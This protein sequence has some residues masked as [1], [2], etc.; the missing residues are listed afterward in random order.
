MRAVER[1]EDVRD[2]RL[3]ADRQARDS[4]SGQFVGHR[5]RDGVGVRFDGDLRSGGEAEGVTH[6]LQ[7]AC[8]V[9][10]GKE[11]RR[12][13]AEEHGRGGTQVAAL[14][15]H[16]H[17][18]ADLPQHL[19]GVGI[20]ARATEFRGGVGVEVAVA[21][22]HAAERHV[23]VDAE[24]GV[25]RHVHV[26]RQGPVDGSGIAERKGRTHQDGVAYSG[27]MARR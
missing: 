13:A 14:P 11:R 19:V 17:R 16:A 15:Q 1:G 9:A 22:A 7:H 23:Q 25:G 21:A 6:A 18:Q 10:R 26:G 2:G 5:R 8:E 3:H 4:G 12:A 24:R 20:L 27:E